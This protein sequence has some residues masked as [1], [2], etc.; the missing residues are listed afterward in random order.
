MSL[1]AEDKDW[2]RTELR[3][4]LDRVVDTMITEMGVRFGEVNG[5]LDRIDATLVNHTKQLASGARSIAGFTEWTSK[6]DA[7][8]T[9][10]LTDLA[11]LKLRVAKLEGPK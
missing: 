7:D 5:R 10:V 8:Y 9:R 6:A 4:G 1:D 11:D 2:I 3:T